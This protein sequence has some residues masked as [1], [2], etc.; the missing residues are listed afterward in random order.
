MTDCVDVR[1]DAIDRLFHEGSE[2]FGTVRRS[3]VTLPQQIQDE[4]DDGGC[5]D[6]GE[7][8]LDHVGT[9]SDETGKHER[10]HIGAQQCRAPRN[11]ADEALH[12]GADTF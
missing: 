11:A 10:E 5:D 3:E 12:L 4:P 8:Q 2:A 9:T 7:H 1:A 6:C